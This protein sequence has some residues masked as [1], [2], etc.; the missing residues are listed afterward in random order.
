MNLGPQTLSITL[1]ATQHDLDS[2]T[3]SFNS[4]V[5]LTPA[6]GGS[7]LT[8]LVASRFSDG[9]ALYLFNLSTA[10]SITLK[11][12]DAG[13]VA[14]NR[15]ACPSS[16]DVVIAPRGGVLV[17]YDTT[18]GLTVPLSNV[19]PTSVGN[20]ADSAV[21][22]AIATLGV[23]QIIAHTFVD[24]AT[25]TYVFINGSKFEIIDVWCI[26]DVAG[27]ANTIQVTDSADAAITNA[28]AF[29]VDKT[30]TH[31]GTI[32]KAKRTLAAAAG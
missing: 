14:A 32:D 22:P 31:A 25:T 7:T 8:G 2:P 9:D 1:A 24:A 28:M 13:S 18:L 30:V 27:A 10:D 21:S 3:Y 11:H 19:T 15:F 12:A 17:V 26:K 5:G 23:P 4:V 16:A 29:A 20:V 6:S